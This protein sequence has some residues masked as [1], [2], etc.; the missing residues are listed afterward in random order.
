MISINKKFIHFIINGYSAVRIK[1]TEIP[2]RYNL[3]D[4]EVDIIIDSAKKI[5]F[6]KTILAKSSGFA[7]IDKPINNI[8]WHGFY[9]KIE[10]KIHLPVINFKSN[11]EK[12]L[13]VRH[14][15]TINQRDIFLFPICSI[16]IP[17]TFRNTNTSSINEE[18]SHILL[19]ETKTHI[20]I[21]FFV[22]PKTISV[23]KFFK[24]FSISMFYLDADIT[25]FNKYFNGEYN[26]LPVASENDVVFKSFNINGWD[27]F[28]RILYTNK[29]REPDLIGRY[30]ILFHDPNDSL[31]MILNRKIAYQDIDNPKNIK[32]T[33]VYERHNNEFKK[34][35]ITL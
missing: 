12:V 18:S 13:C 4:G 23:D 34:K 16:F 9:T 20:R 14:D 24:K 19:L 21:D 2:S 8:S 27:V 25:L 35:R 1:L 28:I 32:W 10:N 3:I 29:T 22:L 26:P 7:H 11:R 5:F 33:T 6:E 31:N 17:N 30:S 15:G